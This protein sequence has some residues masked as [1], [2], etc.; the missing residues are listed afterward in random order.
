L[1]TPITDTQLASIHTA[2]ERPAESASQAEQAARKE[3]N[4]GRSKGKE[5]KGFEIMELK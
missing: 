2:K 3:P 1:D 4:M 5:F